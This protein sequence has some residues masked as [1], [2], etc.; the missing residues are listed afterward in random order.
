MANWTNRVKRY[1]FLLFLLRFLSFWETFVDFLR[2]KLGLLRT[3]DYDLFWR[4]SCSFSLRCNRKSSSVPPPSYLPPLPP[5]SAAGAGAASA[6]LYHHLK[7]NNELCVGCYHTRDCLIRSID[8]VFLFSYLVSLLKIFE[9][10][11]TIFWTPNDRENGWIFEDD[12][13]QRDGSP[14]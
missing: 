10:L 3:I 8:C 14:I 1:F 7:T 9:L 11:E 6:F 13:V 2:H 4:L 5:P 12:D